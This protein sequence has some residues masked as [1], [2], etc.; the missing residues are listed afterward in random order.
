[1]NSNMKYVYVW[2]L[3]FSFYMYFYLWF[4][5]Q[6][7]WFIVY[8]KVFDQVADHLPQ[9]HAIDYLLQA[10]LPITYLG[11]QYR[12]L[13]PDGQGPIIFS[14]AQDAQLFIDQEQIIFSKT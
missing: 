10:Q 3:P 7:R 6:D 2:A 5:L 12:S 1:M 9:A 11:T 14:K 13:I 8:K 4:L